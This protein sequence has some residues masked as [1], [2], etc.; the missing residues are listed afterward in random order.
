MHAA[1]IL[2]VADGV[3]GAASN[4]RPT[5][6]LV[7]RLDEYVEDPALLG[8]YRLLNPKKKPRELWL[9]QLTVDL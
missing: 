2:D 6:A 7:D 5:K 9:Y 1:S 3:T 8:T 4:Q